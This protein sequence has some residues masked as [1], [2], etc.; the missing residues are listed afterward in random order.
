MT[1]DSFAERF[2]VSRET[3]PKL[4][5]YEAM[6]REWN[7][8]INLVAKSTI[9]EVWSR[10]FADSVQL[11]PLL[12]L[13]TQSLTDLGSGGGFPGMVLSILGVQ[14]VQLVESDARKCVF[15]REVGRVTGA[16]AQIHLARAES[17]DLPPASVVTSRALASLELLL[18][19]ATRFLAPEGIC[20]FPKGQAVEE[21]LTRA[22]ESWNMSVERFPSVTDPSGIILR[23]GE[24]ARVR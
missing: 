11:L 2:G 15:L 23:I 1:P 10:H 14:N 21:E 19:L 18:P 12:P 24:I 3:I 13:P 9:D 17:L 4:R 22:G 6:L 16:T 20:L 7:P 8:R 5:R